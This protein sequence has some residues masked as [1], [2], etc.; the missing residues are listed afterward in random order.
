M[1]PLAVN[2]IVVVLVDDKGNPICSATNVAS[3]LKVIVTQDISKFE[4]EAL[5]KPFRS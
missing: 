3:D 2:P 1:I 4:A 5:G